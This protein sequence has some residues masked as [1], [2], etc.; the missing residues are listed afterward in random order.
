ML[1]AMGLIV[2][3]ALLALSSAQEKHSIQEILN[4]VDRVG[5][6]AKELTDS[7]MQED[8]LLIREKIKKKIER[9]QLDQDQ[10][11]AAN[12]LLAFVLR[13]MREGKIT[14]LQIKYFIKFSQSDKL[15]RL[16][17]T[18]DKN[19]LKMKPNVG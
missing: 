2:L 7:E 4:E 3:G 16:L 12:E 9:S 5:H 11:V 15:N 1:A 10:L 6:A 8:F 13:K 18:W 19:L 14:L 17:A